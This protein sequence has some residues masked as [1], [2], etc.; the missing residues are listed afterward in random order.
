[1]NPSAMVP[2]GLALE[3]YF[4][5]CRESEL[6]FRRDDGKETKISAGYFFRMQNAFTSLEKNALELCQG[7]VLDI[8]AGTGS[9]SIF[10][11]QSGFQVT[12]IDICPQAVQIMKARGLKKIYCKDIF[13]F[14]EGEF[15][16][17]LMLGHGIGMVETIA[18]LDKFLEQV[19]SLVSKNGQVLIDSLD[20]QK[21]DDPD[22]L[23]YHRINKDA[24]RYPG[25]IRMQ[26]EFR[27]IKGP[28]FGW[29]QID[30][31][32]L[33]EH[34]EFKSWQCEIII[35]EENGDYLAKLI[36]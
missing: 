13:E 20:V 9:Q 3:D 2:F 22:N 25:E 18:G 14:H 27:G 16:T 6:I 15:D 19:H 24:G 36:R 26:F 33:K 21:T 8:G 1:M 34:A 35:E 7:K 12:S 30:S 29:L 11:K 32:T 28:F 5:G 23:E 10:L 31:E 4:N 17:L